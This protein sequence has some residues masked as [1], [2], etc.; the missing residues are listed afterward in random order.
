MLQDSGAETEQAIRGTC[1]ICK[2]LQNLEDLNV[3]ITGVM[4]AY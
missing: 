4:A 2:W 3:V 1:S